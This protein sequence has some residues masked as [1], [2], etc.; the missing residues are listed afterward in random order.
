MKR[1]MTHKRRQKRPQTERIG[2]AGGVVFNRDDDVLLLKH[3][4]GDWVFPKGHVDPGESDLE[5]AQREV[6]EEAG[7]RT[8]CEDDGFVVKTH[9]VNDRQVA[10]EID[11]FVFETEATE[12]ELR[13]ALFTEGAF[14]PPERALDTL[15]HPQDRDLLRRVLAWRRR[16]DGEDVG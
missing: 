7:V 4:S 11:W 2:G 9:Y 15:S 5:A 12:P 14:L 10:R 13:E 1:P 3:L 16:K 8:W 6:E